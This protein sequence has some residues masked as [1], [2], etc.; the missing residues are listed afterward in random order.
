MA[1][2]KKRA[3]GVSY[4]K[5]R[6][7]WRVYYY[8][9][10]TPGLGERKFENN[11]RTREEAEN[12]AAQIDH[13]LAAMLGV[14]P[15]PDLTLGEV[16]AEWIESLEGGVKGTVKAYRSDLNCY[17]LPASIK[18][19]SVPASQ[20]GIEHFCRVL[21]HVTGRGL[22]ESTL[23]NVVRTLN[24]LT[25]WATLRRKLPATAWGTREERAAALKQA[26][27][28]LKAGRTKTID[29]DQVPTWADIEAFADAL[30]PLYPGHGRNLVLLMAGAGLRVGEALGLQVGDIDVP[31]RTVRV[32][33]QA[34][35]L[36]PWPATKLP[37]GE[38]QRETY[39]W[40]H[41][42]HVLD[43]AIA[44]ADDDGWLFP[45]NV[46]Q[47]GGRGLWWVNRLTEL[48]TTARLSVGWHG[49]GWDNKWC[50]HHYASYS[51]ATKPWGW[52]IPLS[53]VS[54]AL[55]HDKQSTTLDHYNQKTGDS[56][57]IVAAATAS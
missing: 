26:K 23:K 4:E 18:V 24:S 37:K 20:L 51:L 38:K 14:V 21:D 1:A 52:G 19:T 40:S 47:F 5:S 39:M 6:D 56:A 54:A 43:D 7:R 17:V 49:R 44:K 48:T 34:D 10:G 57:A 13:E 41:L 11:H 12:R 22:S 27:I 36:A 3:V 53:V 33:R 15:P 55:G 32:D 2:P 42:A 45:P 29:Y 28:K 31:A 30:E 25:A 9:S 50:R 46:A 35:R 8:P 16:A